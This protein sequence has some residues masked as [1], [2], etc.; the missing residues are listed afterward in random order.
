MLG[1]ILRQAWAALA[2]NPTRSLLTMLGMV[3][4][5]ACAT[6]LIA[7]GT[8]SRAVLVDLF[9]ATGK[10]VVICFGGQTSEQAGGERAGRRIRLNEDDLDH[11][12]AQAT[13]IRQSSLETVRQIPVSYGDRV[14]NAIVRG[15]YPEYGE[16]RNEQPEQGRWISRED[17][18]DRRRVVF[19]GWRLRQKLFSGRPAVGEFVRIQGVRYGVI[20]V[21]YHKVQLWDYFDKDQHAAFIPYPAARELWDAQYATDMVVAPVDAHGEGKAADQVRAVIAARQR[22]LATDKRALQTFGTEEVRSIIDGISIGM[23]ALL[24][25]IGLMTLGIGG[26]GLMNIMLV[27]VDERTREI[28]L[29][30]ALGARRRHVRTQILTETL[31]LALIGGAFGT[32]VAYGVSGLI[33]TI[34]FMGPLM[35]DTTGAS[36]IHLQISPLTIVVSTCFLILVAVLSGWAPAERASNLAPAEALR[37]E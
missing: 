27:S 9:E 24:V 32:A 16:M 19:L 34:P 7:Y 25:V 13:L 26:V 1:E 3:W 23:Q 6:I 15:V 20:G 35:E 21:M 31:T 29:M 30:R 18:Q 37:Y 8:A 36:D 14:E 22:F 2:R 4:G 5:V 17:F 28:G 33:T 10:S 12:R 11:V